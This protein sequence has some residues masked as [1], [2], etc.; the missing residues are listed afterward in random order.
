MTTYKMK[1]SLSVNNIVNMKL[2]F[3]NWSI[4][5]QPPGGDKEAFGCIFDFEL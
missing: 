3:F 2:Y 5:S 1:P 4:Y